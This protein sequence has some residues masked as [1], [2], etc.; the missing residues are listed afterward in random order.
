MKLRKI[1]IPFENRMTK[2]QSILSWVYLLMHVAVLPVLLALLQGYSPDPI[3]D[4][5]LNLIY[6]I[7]GIVFCLTVTHSFL[8]RSFD[9]LADNFRLCLLTIVLGLMINY[10]LS[11][12]A[13]LVLMLVEGVAENPNNSA[14]MDLN[15][16][17]S[18]AVRAVAIFLA[19]IVEE[20]LFRGAVFGSIRTRSRLWAYIVSITAFSLYHIWQY[21]AV[22]GDPAMLLY[23]L[24]YFPV[25]FVLAWIYER[26]G[27]IWTSIFFHMGFNALSLYMLNV[28]DK[29]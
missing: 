11:A 17:D 22:S 24:E 3:S 6:Y 29:L 20:I 26:S 16:T 28:L 15:V 19:P 27:S 10:A 8:R 13:A 23:A 7:I 18:G 2:T 21:A 12:A 1:E 25:S 14:I 9:R 5:T 4:G